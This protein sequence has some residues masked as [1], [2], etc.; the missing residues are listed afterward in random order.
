V[1]DLDLYTGLPVEPQMND[2]AVWAEQARQTATVARSLAPT[3]F[4]PQSLRST[5]KEPDEWLAQTSSNVTAAILTGAELGLTPRAA[6]RSVVVIQGTPTM[7]ALAIRG[8]VQSKGHRVTKIESSDTRCVYEGQRLGSSKPERV[9][10]TIERAQKLGLTGKDNWRKQ[11]EAMLIARASS[12]VCRL[13]AADVLLGIPYSLEEMQ[14]T[15]ETEPQRTA[16]RRAQREPA[17]MPEPELEETP[18]PPAAAPE[19]PQDA[20]EPTPDPITPK[21]LTALNAALSQDLGLTDRED[22]LA[23]LSGE[24]GREI[25]SSKDV[26]KQ[27]A[28]RLLDKLAAE[29]EPAEPPLDGAD[30]PPVTTPGG[31]A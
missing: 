21:Q 14:D 24:L 5:S 8:L 12:E 22:K 17:P 20:P 11:P 26:T 29:R 27:E 25:T 16:R 2:L 7:T 3:H 23:Y 18:E 15:I 19:P 9:V 4:V 10:W 31:A 1:T 6:L 28:M 30:W 13:I